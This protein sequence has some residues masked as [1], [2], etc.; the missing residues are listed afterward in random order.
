MATQL[1]ASVKP[2]TWGRVRVASRRA[3][4][5][6]DPDLERP[7][8]RHQGDT[9]ENLDGDRVRAIRSRTGRRGDGGRIRAVVDL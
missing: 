8:V 2:E 5:D 1:V 9:P 6:L 3:G 4:S 7:A